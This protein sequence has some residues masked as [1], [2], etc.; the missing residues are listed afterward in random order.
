MRRP[1]LSGHC[2]TPTTLNPFQ[3]HERCERQGAGNAANPD[4]EFQP[5]PCE[6]HL[7]ETFECGNC[8]R[9]LR[10]APMWPNE[11]EPGEMVYVHIDREGRAIGEVCNS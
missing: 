2:H 1:M 7:G 11:D 8:G 3:S 9:P 4:K 6:C 10:E 5:C